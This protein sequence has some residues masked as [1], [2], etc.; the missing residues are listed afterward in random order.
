MYQWQVSDALYSGRRSHLVEPYAHIEL[1]IGNVGDPLQKFILWELQK[2]HGD[3]GFGLESNMEWPPLSRL[4]KTLVS[5]HKEIANV[6]EEILN[7]AQ[8][9]LTMAKLRLEGLREAHNTEDLFA[10]KDRLP[11]TIVAFFDS[12]VAQITKSSKSE[13][14]LGLMAL[15]II[16]QTAD[17]MGIGTSEFKI[18]IQE[19][20]PH[21][22]SADN[23]ALMRALHAT[24]GLLSLDIKFHEEDSIL[25]VK[26][27]H[28]DFHIYLVEAY[29]RIISGS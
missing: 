14:V 10:T 9:N 2:E 18:Q 13:D 25:V 11:P 23:L 6:S 22:Q 20:I 15:K 27:Y 24:R 17:V 1:N 21:E 5:D 12:L 8:G 3:L 7:R 16:S 19:S 4:G 29:N 28:S 26:A